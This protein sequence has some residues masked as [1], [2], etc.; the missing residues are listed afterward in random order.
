MLHYSTMELLCSKYAPPLPAEVLTPE[1]QHHERHTFKAMH[2]AKACV[3]LFTISAQPTTH[4]PFI[5]CMGSMATATHI[6]ACEYLLKGP[7]YRHARDR[8]RVFLGILRAFE[9]IWPQ[10]SKWSSEIKLMAKAV[11]ESRDAGGSLILG[12]PLRPLVAGTAFSDIRVRGLEVPPAN[13]DMNDVLD[14]D[15]MGDLQGTFTQ[16]S[17][18]FA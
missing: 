15:G 13:N 1:E 6:S 14:I 10:A 3:E 12:D 9:H 5:M 4:S 16:D 8:V 11:F 18:G 7:E 2:S 17:G